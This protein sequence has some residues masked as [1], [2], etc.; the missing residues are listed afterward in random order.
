MHALSWNEWFGGG[1]NNNSWHYWHQKIAT[2]PGEPFPV[3]IPDGMAFFLA[4]FT[5]AM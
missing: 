3:A 2:F 5:F 1:R 4:L